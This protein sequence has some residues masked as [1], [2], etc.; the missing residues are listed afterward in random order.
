MEKKRPVLI[1]SE[2]TRSFPILIIDKKGFVGSALANKLKEQFLVVLVS[3][4]ELE[5]HNNIV[6][7]PYRKKIPVIPDNSYS[8]I[9]VIYNGEEELLEMMPTFI[10]KGNDTGGRVFFLTTLLHSSAQLFKRLTHHSY[11]SMKVV[12]YGEVFDE[13]ISSPNMINLFIHQA[14]TYGRVVIPNEG[15]GKLYPVYLEDLLIVV[16][17]A[18]F[19]RVAKGGNLFVFPRH[20][21]TEITAARIFQKVNPDLKIDFSKRRIKNFNYYF[22]P[23]GEYAFSNYNLQEGLKKINLSATTQELSTGDK[24]ISL[25]RK[26]ISFNQR[27]I[28]LLVLAILILP[29]L[30]VLITAGAG[31]AFVSQSVRQAEKGNFQAASRLGGYGGVSFAGSVALAEGYFP[32]DVVAK[33]SKEKFVEDLRTGKKVADI[34]ADLFSSL[35]T[36]SD[37]YNNKAVND[38]KTDFTHAVA[39]IKSN[40]LKLEELKAQNQLPSNVHAKLNQVGYALNILENT[41]DSFPQILGFEGKRKYLLLFQNNMEL[42]PGGGFVGSYG[43]VDFDNGRMSEI[44]IHDVYDA[45]GKLKTHVEPPYALRRYGGVSHWF[46][47]D[48]N[49]DVDFT[50]NAAASADL[51]KRATGEEVDGVIAIDTNFIKNILEVL[52]TIRVEDYKEDVNSANFYI[53][54][55]KHSEDNFFPGSTQKKDFLRSLLNSMNAAISEK[56]DFSYLALSRQIEKSIK[57]KHLLFTFADPAI[58]KVFTVNNLSGAIV[59]NRKQSDNTLADFF[60][61]FDANIGAN[62]GNY[63][64]KRSIAQNVNVSDSGQL[65]GS[66]TITYENTSD[67]TSVFGGDYKNYLRFILP[68]GADLRVVTIDGRETSITQ[69]ITNPSA[70]GTPGFVPPQEL[71]IETTKVDDKEVVAFFVIV[72]MQTTKK[73]TVNYSTPQTINI[74]QPAFS[75]SLRLLKQ[76]GTDK[77]PYSLTLSYPSQFKPIGLTRDFVDL[78]GKLTHETTL[79]EDRDI[80]IEFSQK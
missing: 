63:Y 20:P 31:A 29:L 58:Q 18:A 50:N 46:L 13:N 26:K 55:Q 65:F 3:G 59:D 16:I 1:T 53:L 19:S 72:P 15:L 40:L 41:I 45:D 9:F 25:P 23:E 37:I 67:K 42:R 80:K 14:R 64:L 34:E 27:F 4:R 39:N 48:S 5:F 24:T 68:E 36:F 28:L 44:K 49:F 77:D 8:H 6:H 75:Y 2:E 76:P 17:A 69:A 38:P 52:G 35:N 54:T 7:I 56:K 70:F 66:T 11:H 32:A 79:A 33:N 51:L 62:K 43:L 60:A 21:F 78:G 12:L 10:K 47:R 74:S 57:E 22:P 71:E 73:I 61:V 30:F